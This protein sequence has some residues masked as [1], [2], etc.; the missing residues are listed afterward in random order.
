[1]DDIAVALAERQR[2]IALDFRGFGESELAPYSLETLADDVAALL[3]ALGIPIAA[4]GGLSM[5][6]YVALAFARRHPARLG[7]L[8]LADTRAAADSSETKR[9]RT[10]NIARVQTD[11]TAQ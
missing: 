11:G 7:R 5:G 1:W 6:G 4:L 8:I 3:D 2:V 9:G 10:D